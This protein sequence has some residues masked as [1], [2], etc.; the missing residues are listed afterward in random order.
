MLAPEQGPTIEK[1]VKSYAGWPLPTMYTW[2]SVTAADAVNVCWNGSHVPGVLP[3]RSITHSDSSW[4]STLTVALDRIVTV[5][6]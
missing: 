3:V 2:N 1:S 6:A 5:R 4:L